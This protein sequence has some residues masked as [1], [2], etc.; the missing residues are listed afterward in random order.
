MMIIGMM[1]DHPM[2]LN[3][4]VNSMGSNMALVKTKNH[5]KKCKTG[6]LGKVPYHNEYHC[7]W[8]SSIFTL[9]YKKA[10][11]VNMQTYLKSGRIMN[12]AVIRDGDVWYR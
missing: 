12:K 4:T 11:Q 1:I 8:C 6:K 9:P 10:R 2:V 7:D 5:C 3:I